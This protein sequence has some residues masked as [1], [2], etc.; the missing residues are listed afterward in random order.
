MGKILDTK[1]LLQMREEGKTL[2]EIASRFNVSFQAISQRLKLLQGYS[3]PASLDKLTEKEKKFAV[4]VAGGKSQ[5]QA[6]FDAYDVVDRVS[7]KAIG[8]KLMKDEG[9]KA[10]VTDLMEME[11]LTKR[12]RVRRL[13]EIVYHKDP[14]AA[15]RGLD[16]CWK[17]DGSYAP[18]KVVTMNFEYADMIK[19]KREIL[20]EMAEL[21]EKYGKDALEA[22]IEEDDD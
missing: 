22:A 11:G 12:N 18:T 3:M 4:A 9:V 2:K 6:A 13:K 5:T 17:L 19:R 16:Q 21:E 20:A 1:L 7:A 10:A 15:I 14:N 8:H